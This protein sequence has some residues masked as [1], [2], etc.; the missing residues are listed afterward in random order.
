M[1][2]NAG[3]GRGRPRALHPRQPTALGDQGLGAALGASGY[4]DNTQAMALGAVALQCTTLTT[5]AWLLDTGQDVHMDKSFSWTQGDWGGE[6][7]GGAMSSPAPSSS[8]QMTTKI[9]HRHS[10]PGS[11]CGR[12]GGPTHDPTQETSVHW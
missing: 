9:C 7:G 1:C 10:A 2:R 6:G 3:S 4:A 11:N 8:V 5:E 12:T